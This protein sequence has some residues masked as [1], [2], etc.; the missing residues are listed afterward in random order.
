[1]ISARYKITDL[2]Q[3]DGEVLL[4]G[5]VYSN[6]QALEAVTQAADLRN[7]P[8]FNRICTG[9]MVGYCADTYA[10]LDRMIGDSLGIR[11]AGNVEKQLA[12]GQADCG[13][14]FEEGSQC[15]VASRRWFDEAQQQLSKLPDG[16]VSGLPDMVVFRHEGRRYAVIHGGLT[17]ISRFIWPNSPEAVFAEEVSAIEHEVGRVDGVIAGHSGIAFERHVAGRQWINAGVVGMPPHDGRPQTRY[18]VLGPDGV[19]FH[20]LDYDHQDAASAMRDRG[21][22][23]GYEVALETG[24]WPSEDVLPRALRR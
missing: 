18:A 8:T 9:D 15:D 4:F 11:V 1:M 7:I 24:I 22:T 3:L 21:L 2:E 12:E 6:V 13:C 23:Q 19:R 5:G 10:V 14:G 17:N 16:F 20:M